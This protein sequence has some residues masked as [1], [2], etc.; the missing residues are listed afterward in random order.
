M[1][2]IWVFKKIKWQ[3]N[4]M[5]LIIKTQPHW[6]PPP[7]YA[8]FLHLFHSLNDFWSSKVKTQLVPVEWACWLTTEGGLGEMRGVW[9]VPFSAGGRWGSLFDSDTSSPHA[10]ICSTHTKGKQK[11]LKSC[12]FSPMYNQRDIS[13]ICCA[14]SW[15]TEGYSDCHKKKTRNNPVL[16]NIE[17]CCISQDWYQITSNPVQ[18]L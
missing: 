18:T 9:F 15:P 3:N 6:P 4:L 17:M 2:H 10:S 14:Y 7:W 11:N 1:S 13:L 12:Q 5:L 8:L 16:I